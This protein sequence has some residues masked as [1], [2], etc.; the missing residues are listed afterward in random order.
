MTDNANGYV[1]ADAVQ[2][3]SMA[4]PQAQLYFI[5]TDQLNTPRLITNATGQAVWTW[6]N[7]DPFG[8]NAP[9]ENPSNLGAFTCN[10]RLP[11]QYFDKETNTHYN[12]FRITDPSTGR[13]VESDP[14]GLE[15][16]INSYLFAEG[17]PIAYLDSFGLAP[18]DNFGSKSAAENDAQQYLND[19][20][21]PAF[22]RFFIGPTYLTHITQVSVARKYLPILLYL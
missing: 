17:N 5:Y 9:N 16:G 13:Y 7:D 1:I 8:N 12:Y 20:Y 21:G 14:V 3:I 2:L 15:G 4:P 6:A 18:G 10:L 11:G 22:L 19:Q